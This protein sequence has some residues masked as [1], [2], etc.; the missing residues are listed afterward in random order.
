MHTERQSFELLRNSPLNVLIN[1][2][3]YPLRPIKAHPCFV[4]C[5]GLIFFLSSP[6][7]TFKQ[8]SVVQKGDNSIHQIKVFPREDNWSFFPGD[9]AFDFLFLSLWTVIYPG[10]SKQSQVLRR[11]CCH[12]QRQNLIGLI[13]TER[14]SLL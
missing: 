11:I 13:A 4:L 6:R 10:D 12:C 1:Y 5:K 8:N 7:L 14:T 9:N 3:Q 2:L